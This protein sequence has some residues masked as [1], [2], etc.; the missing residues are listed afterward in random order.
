MTARTC[1]IY[2]FIETYIHRHGYA[3]TLREIAHGTNTST[4]SLVRYHLDKLQDA[5]LIRRRR[6]AARALT[7]TK[8]PALAGGAVTATLQEAMPQ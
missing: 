8:P 2:N 7:L 1:D 5:G 3:P 6:Y 4:I